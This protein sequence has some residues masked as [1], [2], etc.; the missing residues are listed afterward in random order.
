[1]SWRALLSGAALFVYSVQATFAA[2][3]TLLSAGAVEP[4]LRPALAAFEQMSG[5]QVVLQFA[6]APQIR[7]RVKA[8]SVVFN[9]AS[10]GLN[11]EPQLKKLGIEAQV[12]PETTRH[13]DGA[14]VMQH[15]LKG[16]GREIGFGAITEILLLHDT[17]L[18][19]VGPLP[20]ELQN[21]TAYIATLT[22]GGAQ[23]EA[24]QALLRHLASSATQAGFVAAGIGAL[25]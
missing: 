5:H 4:G 19:F 23:H 9:R 11:F 20:P 24:A 21:F 10:T 15:L 3:V 1:M 6:A 22:P 18:Q 17:G 8:D 12:L 14:S 16:Q 25:P 7:A 13:A 2:Q